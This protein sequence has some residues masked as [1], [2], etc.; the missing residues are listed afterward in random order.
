MLAART[1]ALIRL[2]RFGEAAEWGVKIAARPNAHG[3]PLAIAAFSLALDGRLEEGRAYIATI[4]K[5]RPH[6][7]LGDFLT[8]FQLA[9]QGEKIFRDIAKIFAND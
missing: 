7:G 2:G 9:P 4:R 3:H 8:A 5:T 1:M 6:Y